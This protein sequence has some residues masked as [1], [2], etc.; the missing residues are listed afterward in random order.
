[1]TKHEQEKINGWINTINEIAT[2]IEEMAEEKAELFEKRSEKWQNSDEG[3]LLSD[4]IHELEGA[5]DGLREIT[6]KLQNSDAVSLDQSRRLWHAEDTIRE[7][8]GELRKVVSTL[9]S[10]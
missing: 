6:K 9:E 5:A 2:G 4:Q 8:A 3:G 7:I 1:M 10:L